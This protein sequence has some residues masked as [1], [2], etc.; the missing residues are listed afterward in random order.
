MGR[1]MVTTLYNNCAYCAC[2]CFW[3]PKV[4]P[5]KCMLTKSRGVLFLS[6]QK[7]EALLTG[8]RFDK[9]ELQVYWTASKPWVICQQFTSNGCRQRNVWWNKLGFPCY[10]V[11]ECPKGHP[12]Y[13]GDV[14]DA[15]YCNLKSYKFK[16]R[17][18]PWSWWPY[19]FSWFIFT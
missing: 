6:V 15:F 10:F 19:L 16:T 5:F 1:Q 18:V 11:A 3:Y 12:Y 14:S 8:I 2:R 9:Y 17:L 13:I 7:F 4:A